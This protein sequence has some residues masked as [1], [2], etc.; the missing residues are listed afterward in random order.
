M[1]QTSGPI[2]LSEIALEL[3]HG[4]K[5]IGMHI[6]TSSGEKYVLVNGEW[7]KIC[8]CS[9]SQPLF[10]APFSIFHWYGYDHSAQGVTGVDIAGKTAVLPFET[11]DYS[12]IIAGPNQIGITLL[13]ESYSGSAW[14]VAG[15][16]T[17]IS[18]TWGADPSIQKLRL[19][20]L[21]QCQG[22]ESQRE[23]IITKKGTY[24]N[25]IICGVDLGVVRQTITP[26]STVGQVVFW[27]DGSEGAYFWDG[28]VTDTPTDYIGTVHMGVGSW[29]GG[30]VITTYYEIQRC[31]DGA[32]FCTTTKIGVKNQRVRDSSNILYTYTGVT[33][34]SA[35][36]SV[37]S[38]SIIHGKL[39]CVDPIGDPVYYVLNKCGGGPQ[40]H[41]PTP[42]AS[43]NMRV[44][45]GVHGIYVS[46]GTTT[47]NPTNDVGEVNA[48]GSFG[49][50][51]GGS[52]GSGAYKVLQGCAGSIYYT[53]RDVAINGQKFSHG[54]YGEMYWNGQTT[55]SPGTIIA[56]TELV[57]LANQTG[58]GGSGGTT[59]YYQLRRCGTN[60]HY[61]TL[62]NPGSPGQRVSS[63][64]L[65]E[66]IYTG[67]TTT[68][69]GTI[70]SGV[71]VLSGQFGCSSEGGNTV[72]KSEART[73]TLQKK[74][75]T[76]GI[77]SYVDVTAAE[78]AFEHTSSVNDANTLRDTWMQ[79]Y[80]NEHGT[81]TSAGTLPF[82]SMNYF[83]FWKATDSSFG[84]VAKAHVG[85]NNVP[86]GANIQVLWNYDVVSGTA[87]V[88]SIVSG[89][90]DGW[91]SVEVWIKPGDVGYLEITYV[92]TATAENKT[93]RQY[94]NYSQAT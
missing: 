79:N 64:S 73:A 28:T 90:A 65:G 55:N 24:Y 84:N 20:V 74:N 77:G 51:D 3:G 53:L 14:S 68:S 47:T 8:K 16:G 82:P 29:C 7:V 4:G 2:G 49:C 1:L 19:R 72:Y 52:S 21:N 83:S 44:F 41:T 38:V 87:P 85:A 23:V 88:H 56:P 81:C 63:G 26:I 27:G 46:A 86:S 5:D 10:P 93:S 78:G 37:I 12:A 35:S 15:Y 18:I 6:I 33:R 36:Y 43:A 91:F 42:L 17:T 75:C 76:S 45:A 89:P 58:C 25:L 70:I 50:D 13:W 40:A 57:P 71:S 69:P 39:R 48:P 62:T 59:T 80:A 61:Y 34:K 30:S 92:N 22:G 60:D 31:S 94:L 54:T 9:H 67:G 32:I 11:V 66:M